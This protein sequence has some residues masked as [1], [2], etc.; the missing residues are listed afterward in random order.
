MPET[1]DPYH[2]WL[3]IPPEEQPPNH[4][5]L[6][7]MKVFEPDPDVIA[8]TA[9][10]RIGHIRSFQIGEHALLSQ[11][12]LNEIAAARVCLLDS[13]KKAVYDAA[14]LRDLAKD[15]PKD[16][17]EHGLDLEKLAYLESLAPAAVD[18]RSNPRRRKKKVPW[19][20]LAIAGA[21]VLVLAIIGIFE[22]TVGSRDKKDTD[23]T[24]EQ[25]FAKSKPEATVPAEK[26]KEKPEP[27][28]NAKANH[29]VEPA[30]PADHASQPEPIK[31]TKPENTPAAES[32]EMAA[33]RLKQALANAKTPEDFRAVARRGLKL[34]EL[35]AAGGQTD[36]TKRIATIALIAAREAEDDTLAADATFCILKGRRQPTRAEEQ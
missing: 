25:L 21:A 32:P 2:K 36:L 5:R 9:D 16:K 31:A 23:E 10:Q 35:A 8:H 13:K 14:L 20:L 33:K 7:G 15:L 4:Y 24:A 30:R 19:Q 12:L 27:D 29:K 11:R 6:L 3:G 17:A 1:F 34:F 18:K 26:P 28:L 22:L